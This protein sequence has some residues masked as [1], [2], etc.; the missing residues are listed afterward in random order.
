MFKT[1][2]TQADPFKMV[3]YFKNPNDSIGAIRIIRRHLLQLNAR[4][5]AVNAEAGMELWTKDNRIVVIQRDGQFFR[6]YTSINFDTLDTALEAIDKFFRM[7][8]I[9]F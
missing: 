7:P 5:F 4:R 6:L 9:E 2:T 8:K 1:T 3:A